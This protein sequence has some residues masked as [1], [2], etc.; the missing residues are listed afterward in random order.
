MINSASEYEPDILNI[1]LQRGFKNSKFYKEC[2]SSLALSPPRNFV[3]F[4]GRYLVEY[5]TLRAKILTIS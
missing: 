2:M 5:Y 3:V 4:E 1:F